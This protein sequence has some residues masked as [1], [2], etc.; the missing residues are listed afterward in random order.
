[1]L[2]LENNIY[3]YTRLVPGGKPTTAG[4]EIY[5]VCTFREGL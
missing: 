1:M 4:L 5:M 2:Q 3:N